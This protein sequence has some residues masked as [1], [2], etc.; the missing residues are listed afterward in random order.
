MMRN[1]VLAMMLLIL[2][3]SPIINGGSD[4]VESTCRRTPNYELCVKVVSSDPRAQGADDITTLAIIMVDAIKAKSQETAIMI[5]NL[6]KT[7]EDLK[8]ALEQC[9]F[10]YK[11]IL[12]ASIPEAYEALTKGVPK[13]AEKGVVASSGSSQQ[14][15]LGFQKAQSPLT[16]LNTEVHDLSDV[17]TA[18]IKILL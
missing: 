11:V 1:L 6:Q 8:T 10:D 9:A 7:R 4:L 15:E 3:T 13:F 2:T 17:A 18:I 16:A 14:C 5:N 12:T